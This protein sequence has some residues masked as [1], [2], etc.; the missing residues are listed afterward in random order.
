M[1]AEDARLR[2]LN[3]GETNTEEEGAGSKPNRCTH[4]QSH[5]EVVARV[6]RTDLIYSLSQFSELATQIHSVATQFLSTQPPRVASPCLDSDDLPPPEYPP[7]LLVSSAASPSKSERPPQ[8]NL[9]SVPSMPTVS[10]NDSPASPPLLTKSRQF[11]FLRGR[12]G[13][14]VWNQSAATHARSFVCG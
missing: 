11:G 4:K 5:P 13:K 8:L 7:A 2:H 3:S 14:G 10:N 6:K 9:S 1:E 12:H